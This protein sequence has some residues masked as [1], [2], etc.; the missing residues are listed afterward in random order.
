MLKNSN[1]VVKITEE[2][3]EDYISSLLNIARLTNKENSVLISFVVDNDK[4]NNVV[5]FIQQDGTRDQLKNSVFSNDEKFY[6]DFLEKF[7]VDYS[8]NMEVVLTDKIDMNDD[9]K[10][11]YR[12]ITDD[13]DMLSIDGIT[14]E[15]ANY[16]VSLIKKENQEISRDINEINKESGIATTLISFILVVGI[17][18]SFLILSLFIS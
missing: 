4:S 9:G 18:I 12:I 15:Y 14:L 17:G 8:N 6:K 5:N 3:Y 1:E 7:V 11:T 2:K 13:N 16:L 10:Y